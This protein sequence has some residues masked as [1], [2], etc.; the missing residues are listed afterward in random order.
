MKT[1]ILILRLALLLLL[2]FFASSPRAFAAD[3]AETN[4]VN[5][6]ADKISYEEASGIATAEGNVQIYN[7]DMRLFAPYLE[8][9]GE[10]H[11]VKALSTEE[12]AVTF[13]S[14]GRKLSGER[15]DYNILTRKGLLTHPNGKV[16]QIFIRGDAIE[17]MPISEI[18]GRR[19]KKATE[20]SEEVAG[21]WLKATITTCPK[22]APHY[23]LEAREVVVIPDRR[24]IVRKP[25]VYLGKHMLFA[26]PFDY[27]VPLN[28]NDRRRRGTLFPK[29]GYES[30][31]GAGLGV[32]G[33]F[34][35]KNGSLNME[36][37]GWTEDIW[38]GSARLEQQIQPGLTVYGDVTREYDK[39]RDVTLWR[40]AWGLEYD[41][42]GWMMNAG[43]SQR[44]LVT[45]EKTAGHDMRY[46]VWR[47]PEVSIL[48]PW[49]DD[50]AVG[51]RFRLFGS[52]G[53]YEDASNGPAPTIE[54]AGLGIQTTGEFGHLAG[55]NFQPFYNALYWY[56][57]YDAPGADDQQ[58]LDTVAGIRWH[59]GV[60][61]METAY[62]R[63]WTWGDSPMSWDDYDPREEIYQSLNVKLPTRA[64][65]EWWH[66]GVRGAYSLD[67]S[68]LA[69]MVYKVGYEQDCMLWELMYRDDR[70]GDDSWIGLKLTIKAYP[71]SGLRLAG[72][73]IFDPSTAPDKLIPKSFRRE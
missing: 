26:Y 54:R 38:E 30:K 50:R 9:D 70:T 69:E 60:F 17:V 7:R 45:V 2:L 63:R 68:E 57:T 56:Y 8:Y 55:D 10:T 64:N 32:S 11:Q 51:G 44:E 48:S 33:P 73:D 29:I 28:P 24:V 3:D 36:V 35:W 62:L 31:K 16:D 43:W 19:A 67:D 5:L 20:D 42:N 47:Q 49:F 15:L 1:H 21:R 12:G 65:D 22:P 25:R 71:E 39:D 66:L 52:W 18:T 72:D 23:R 27:V 61:N 14:G 37:I 59:A 58:I 6:N 4:R 34:V 53:R 40:P 13:V 46:V 41:W